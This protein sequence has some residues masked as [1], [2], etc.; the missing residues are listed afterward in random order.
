MARALEGIRV[1]D[2][3]VALSG[4][5][6]TLILGDLGA[7]VIK[8]EPPGGEI[9]R[10]MGP[11]FRGDWSS[12]FVGINRNKKG[13]VL[14]LKSDTGRETFY[15]LVKIADVVVDNYRPGVAEKL[16]VEPDRLRALN[17]RLITASITG[18]GKGVF[19]HRTA[20]DLCVQ[21]ASGILSITGD[22]EGHFVKVGVP[23]GD[24]AAGMFTAIGILTALE[25]RHR[26]GQGQ[27]VDVTM[28]DSQISLLSYLISWYTMS[29]DVP[30]PLGTGHPGIEPYG[31]FRTG[32]GHLVL[33]IAT[34]RFWWQ[35]CQVLGVPDLACDPRFSH[36]TRRHENKVELRRILEEILT[37]RTTF[38]WMRVMEE[39]GIPAAPLNTVDKALCEPCVAERNM[40]VE[41][42]QPGYE[43]K[44]RLAGNPIKLSDTPS[45]E[46]APAPYLGEHTAQLLSELLGYSQ[47]EIERVLREGAGE[48]LP[49]Y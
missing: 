3:T 15:D 23:I 2:L 37:T 26:S 22:R 31:A 36:V 32:D 39:A 16:R 44:A 19:K 10:S 45:E 40:L 34:E 48:E 21:A 47:E 8:V 24:L 1:L 30:K 6:C 28:F 35:L 13:I 5:F 41:V 27:H 49:V 42:A 14:D 4:P 17:P 25:T 18:F 46:F 29:G 20:F 11:Y 9:F 7:E 12:Y 38:E 33:T 43:G